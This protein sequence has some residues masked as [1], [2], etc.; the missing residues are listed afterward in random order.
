MVEILPASRR[1]SR[2]SL[3]LLT[4]RCAYAMPPYGGGGNNNVS[5]KNAKAWGA[6]GNRIGSFRV[7]AWLSDQTHPVRPGHEVK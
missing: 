7:F 5:E 4:M 3:F 6:F 2:D 1:N